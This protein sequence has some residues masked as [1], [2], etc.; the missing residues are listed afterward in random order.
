MPLRNTPS[1]GNLRTILVVLLANFHQDWIFN[2]LAYVLSTVVDLVLVPEWRVLRDVDPLALVESVER[3]LSKVWVVFDLVCGG[4]GRR[5]AQQ[6]LDLS[7][8]EVRNAN[9]PTFSLLDQLLHC[10]PGL[11]R[12]SQSL[13]WKGQLVTHI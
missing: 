3:V 8:R 10:F 13:G 5:L 4:D 11:T 6:T 2:Q 1:Q 7:L 9:C 12:V